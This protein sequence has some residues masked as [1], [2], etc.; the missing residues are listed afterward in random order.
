MSTVNGSWARPKIVNDGLVLYLD[1]NAPNSYSQ[2]FTPTT[3]K[4]LSGNSNNGTLTNGP[5]FN[6]GN[7][8]SIVFDGV[9]DFVNCGNGSSL[10]FER[11]NSFTLSYWGYFTSLS[12][13]GVVLNRTDATAKGWL[14]G[15]NSNG[16]ISVVLRN[17]TT[18]ND[19][20]IQT[21]AG[22]ILI[23]NWYFVTATYNGNLNATGVSFYINGTKTT[24]DIIIRNG[25]TANI[26]N[27]DNV[28]LGARVSNNAQYFTGNIAQTSIYNRA[29]SATEV[30][31]NYNATKTRF[32]L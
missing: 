7:G 12:G 10:N 28:T 23:N 3:W 16:S 17:T 32:G 29:L 18:T 2:Y 13:G 5:T 30:L 24:G 9:D 22:L 26:A 6:S 8:G 25:L 14:T 15:Y 19:I 4:D 20:L 31:Q 11:T 1:A 27:T 21:S